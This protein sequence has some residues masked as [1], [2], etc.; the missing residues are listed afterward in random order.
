MI[1]HRKFS[2]SKVWLMY[3]HFEIR[4][5][6]LPQ[7][8]KILGTALGKAPKNKIYRQY[9][10]IVCLYRPS[11]T[12]IFTRGCT[13]VVVGRVW[14]CCGGGFSCFWCVVGGF[15]KCLVCCGEGFRVFG[16]LW[17]GFS[18]VWCVVRR[19]FVCLVC[20]G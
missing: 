8:R 4:Q 16:V 20:C 15:G 17:G 10:G 9:I 19:V 13:G 1:P 12:D 7:A 3:A 2:F 11:C 18:C 5:G 14:G 6:N